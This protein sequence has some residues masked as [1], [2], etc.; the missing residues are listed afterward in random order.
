MR[1]DGTKF[2]FGAVYIGL[3]AL[4]LMSRVL[5]YV[6]FYVVPFALVGIVFGFLWNFTCQAE[7]VS[8]RRVGFLIPLTALLLL[9]TVGFPS[10]E[11]QGP[12]PAELQSP[13]LFN[14]FNGM[15]S[16][17][18]GGLNW[19]WLSYFRYWLPFLL[20]PLRYQFVLYDLR[21]L[22]WMLWLGLFIAAPAVFLCL[23]VKAEKNEIERIKG[24]YEKK[25][26]D[27]QRNSYGFKD[28]LARERS[29]AGSAIEEKDREIEKL[30]AVVQAISIVGG[31]A[32]GGSTPV[33]GKPPG[34][35]GK[36]GGVF[37]SDFL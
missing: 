25:L 36:G 33:S 8:Y 23:S 27:E 18:D 10:P 2:L 11:S 24:E 35:G 29:S 6:V 20:P 32:G 22:S 34:D 13:E 3:P 4:Y 26:R 7:E 17:L 12:L 5:P 16:Y 31:K 30:K 28:A 15:K 21:D 9:I 1:D 37:G 14:A 19:S